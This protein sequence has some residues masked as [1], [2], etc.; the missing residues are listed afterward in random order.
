MLNGHRNGK[1]S[2]EH[3]SKAELRSVNQ[4]PEPNIGSESH[5]GRHYRV[6][7]NEVSC[8]C[9]VPQLLHLT[10][11]HFITACK[12]RGLNHESPMYMSPL[13]SRE[14]TIKIWESSFEPYL[15]P[16]QWPPYEGLEYVPNS[17]LKRNNIGRR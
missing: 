2:Y 6:D 3:I 11:S 13:Y 17:N 5:G 1:V 14:H 9:N 10:C 12:A 15:D 4:L 7:L 16:S 8:T